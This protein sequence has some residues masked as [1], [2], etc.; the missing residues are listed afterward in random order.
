MA[1]NPLRAKLNEEEARY[2]YLTPLPVQRCTDPG[3]YPI[4]ANKVVACLCGR[5]V[6]SR[7]EKCYLTLPVP[8]TEKELKKLIARRQRDDR[9]AKAAY[10]RERRAYLRERRQQA[11]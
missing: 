2:G 4:T 7:S 3:D 10:S 8:K 11:E 5:R 6:W 1:K 9:E